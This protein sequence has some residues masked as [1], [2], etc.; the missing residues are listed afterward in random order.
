MKMVNRL[1]RMIAAV[2]NAPKARAR[3]SNLR[4]NQLDGLEEIGKDRSLSTADI[5]DVDL[6]FFGDY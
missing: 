1:T 5:Q 4:G 6:V 3:D 2:K